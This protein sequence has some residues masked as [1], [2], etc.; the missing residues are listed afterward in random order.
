MNR[1]FRHYAGM[2]RDDKLVRAAV[3]SKQPVERVVWVWGAILESAAELQDGGR[4][5][6]DA[7]EAAYFLR[8]EPADLVTISDA[9]CDLGRID[10]GKVT[11][12]G[13]RQF[14]SD[15]SRE[16]QQRYRDRQKASRVTPR[17]VTPPSPNGAV[18]PQEAETE[19]ESET[20][21]E[22]HPPPSVPDAEGARV[23]FVDVWEA[24]PQNPSSTEIK[25]KAAFDR[26]K[27]ADR[28]AVLDEAIRYSRWFAADCEERDRTL[29]AGL[30]FV[31]H[32]ST[33]LDGG[34]WREAGALRLKGEPSG[35]VVPMVR[36]DRSQDDA[37]WR[38]CERI[39]GRA[40]PTSDWSWA[41]RAEVVDQARAN[42]TN[43][44][45]AVH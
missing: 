16:R 39:M 25:A 13:D 28:Q 40:A 5:D 17:D 9:L 12:W 37:L 38:E 35:P 22:I 30:R 44:P 11:K 3:R 45:K 1:W 4:Y 32:L 2:M 8:C 18:T 34:Q 41:F 6:F 43:Q 29:D 24:F 33:W 23:D 26:L 36:L 15:G 42:L 27:P 20:K 19:T 14:E 7:D 31:P 10:S 21:T